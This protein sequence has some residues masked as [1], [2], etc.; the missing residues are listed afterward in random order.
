[1]TISLPDQL[2]TQRLTLRAPRTSDAAHLFAAYTQDSAVARYM[3]WRPHSLLSQTEGFIDYCIR[4]LEA[5]RGRPY[6]LVPH[7]NDDVPVGMLEARLQTHT[8]DIGYVL[9]RSHWGEGLMPEAI[10]AFTE[11]ALSLPE[12]FRVQA[13]CDTENL[14]SARTLEK[15]GFVREG[16]LERHAVLPNLG[17][18]PR[19]SFMYARWK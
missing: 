14:A 11:A 9:Q 16:R 17:A 2:R 3:T 1:M 7:D 4:G 5:D 6:L 19:A 10:A 8:I 13:T 12:Y 15:S 18:E